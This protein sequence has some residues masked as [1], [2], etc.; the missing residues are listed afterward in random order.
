MTRFIPTAF[1][2]AAALPLI[3]C[4][5]TPP[6][7]D[8]PV[9]GG[10]SGFKCDASMLGDLIGKPASQDLGTD[11]LKRSGSR[12]LRWIQPNTAVTMDY[13]ED[14]LNIRLDGQNVVTG[15]NCG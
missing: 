3:A 5:Q 1:A 4:A 13:R 12:N 9:M 8:T 10:G 2:A 7:D 15:S 14:R 11:A 6:I